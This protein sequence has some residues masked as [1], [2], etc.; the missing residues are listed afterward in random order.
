MVRRTLPEIA[1]PDNKQGYSGHP[2]EVQ[3]NY[4]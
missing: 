4:R 1:I 3:T 2:I